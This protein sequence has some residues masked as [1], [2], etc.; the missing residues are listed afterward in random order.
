MVPSL[1]LSPY[2]YLAT[3]DGRP[4]WAEQFVD[5]GHPVHLF[6]PPRNVT[7]GGMTPDGFE[8]DPRAVAG[9]TGAHAR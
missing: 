5:S 4:G 1:G 2:I 7:A 9:V 3:P 6:D 8:A